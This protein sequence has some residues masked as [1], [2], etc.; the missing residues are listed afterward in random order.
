MLRRTLQAERER[1][2]IPGRRYFAIVFIAC[3][4]M[5]MA[6]TAVIYRQSTISNKYN[7]EVIQSYELLRKARGVLNL[8][9]D[10]ETGQ[11]GY[12]LTGNEPYLAPYNESLAALGREIK[13]LKEGTKEGSEQRKVVN[14]I[15]YAVRRVRSIM[16]DQILTYQIEGPSGITV[17]KLNLSKARVDSVR[18]A[19]EKF[20]KAEQA[21]LKR[22]E[23][24]A[25]RQN[26][27]YFLT[28]FVGSALAVG[29]M[30][31]ANFIILRLIARQR[32]TE[33]ELR[34]FEESYRLILEGANDGIFDYYPDS[35]L[36]YF[37]PSY[38]A[39]LGYDAEEMPGHVD[40]LN[41]LI[42]PDDFQAT[43]DLTERFMRKD[44]N[45]FTSVFR[46]KHKDGSWRWILARAV[47]IWDDNGTIRRLVGTH[48]DISQQKAYEEQLK[49]MNAELEGFT[50]IA[51]HDLRAPLVNLKGFAG[52]LERAYDRA[53]PILDE[54]RPGLDE[55]KRTVLRETFDEDIPE[56]L[57]FIHSSVEKMDKLTSAILDLSRIGRRQYRKEAVDVNAMVKRCM[58]S[59]A[60]EMQ[61]KGVEY[62]VDDFPSVVSD[63]LALEQIFSNLLDNAVKYLDPKRKGK[64]AVEHKLLPG[65]HRFS[66]VDNGRGIG[67]NDRSRVFDIFRR[68]ANSGDVRGIGMGMAYVKAMV[69]KLGG[70]I[71]FESTIDKG[72]TFYF[73]L[74]EKL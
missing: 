57:G 49:Q 5:L 45:E 39:L 27:N 29:G 54:V 34:H 20:I 22:R 13:G 67:E 68:A 30:V 28:L 70:R 24:A 46:L 59:L 33:A 14:E 37:S 74:P 71:W 4:I 41:K 72:S 66:I 52:E 6:F 7:D 50:Y 11:R 8:T 69:R 61:E 53:K 21:E 40:T 15:E 44:T 26:Y 18:A 12:L 47:G 51:S 42:H 2:V 62:V 19:V 73:T 43:W 56:A 60:F 58:D 17:S 25:R 16:R 48:T 1:S 31:I 9:I 38:H 10:L 35:K 23:S 3:S 63:P 32:K 64:I 55:E 36:M 65:E